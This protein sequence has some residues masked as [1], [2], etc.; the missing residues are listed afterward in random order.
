[1]SS[2]KIYCFEI[3]WPHSAL[4]QPNESLTT[5]PLPSS[6]ATK[7]APLV[8]DSASKA[9]EVSLASD[10]GLR[11]AAVALGGVVL[12]SLTAGVGLLAGLVVVGIGA[13]AGGGAVALNEINT[14]MEKKPE[15]LGIACDGIEDA[16][17]WLTAIKNEIDSLILHRNTADVASAKPPSSVDIFEIE[18]WINS[19][20]WESHAFHDGFKI[21][22]LPPDRTT[23]TKK[24]S[25]LSQFSLAPKYS[26][27]P[28]QKLSIPINASPIQVYE[29]IRE[30]PAS[31]C[32]GIIKSLRV[33]E[34][35]DRFTDVIYLEL[36]EVFLSPTMTGVNSFTYDPYLT[37]RCLFTL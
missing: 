31:C 22:S 4:N 26:P 30:F 3:T 20:K 5:E 36:S 6:D 13:A 37:K 28:C 23:S 27:F 32:T 34:V 35:I 24:T 17:A 19:T 16:K 33:I 1:M 25:F 8:A 15:V 21:Y 11:V 14:S 9:K 2:K 18:S 29:I 10:V 12:G 7:T